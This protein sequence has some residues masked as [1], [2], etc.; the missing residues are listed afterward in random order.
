M[1]DNFIALHIGSKITISQLAS[2]VFLGES[3]FYAIFKQEFGTTPYQY[4][5]VKRLDFAK[6]LLNQSLLSI[7]DIAQ[8]TGF[9]NQSAFSHAF[10]KYKGVSP[11]KYRHLH[12][13][14]N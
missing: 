5:I 11:S 14:R 3:Q 8:Q 13:I 2:T 12:F 9:A 6:K 10:V 1:I 7:G 4:I